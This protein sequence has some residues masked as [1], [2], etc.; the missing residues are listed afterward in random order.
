MWPR[1]RGE[2]VFRSPDAHP[3]W[4]GPLHPMLRPHIASTRSS[5]HQ[6]STTAEEG[7]RLSRAR[8]TGW[9]IPPSP[10][11]PVSPLFPKSLT[12]FH[13]FRRGRG[14]L[15]TTA[16]MSI[17]TTGLAGFLHKRKQDENRH[18]SVRP[19]DDDPTLLQ[20]RPQG[21]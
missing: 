9:L 14:F 20:R 11:F 18:L 21:K 12:F 10:D 1:P 13:R 15:S 8:G 4:P 17:A 7:P 19:T 6:I 16:S 5:R 2:K 3:H